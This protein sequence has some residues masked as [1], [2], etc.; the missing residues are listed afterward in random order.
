MPDPAAAMANPASTSFDL[1][2]P[3]VV[4]VAGTAVRLG[5][6]RQVAVLARLLLTPG[7]V[8]SMEQLAESV[9]DGDLPARPEV[10]IRSYIS[11]LR[12]S[13]EPARHPGDRQSC[14]E[15]IAPG[16]R[17]AVDPGAIDA[18]RFEQLVAQG[19]SALGRGDAAPAA[20]HLASALRL[21][22]GEPCE[23]LVDTDAL[24]AYRSRLAELRLVATEQWFEARLALGEHEALT[25]DLEAV[26]AEHPRRERLTELAMLAL[27]RAGRQSEAL[28]ACRRLRALLV[29]QLGI[30]PGPRV[31]ALEHKIL[32]HDPSLLLPGSA[33][34]AS[35][36]A[37]V[38][39]AA[40]PAGAGPVGGGPGTAEVSV[41][42]GTADD[43]AA[44][45]TAAADGAAPDGSGH[46][47]G[48]AP[49][50]GR[51]S[52][53]DETADAREPGERAPGDEGLLLG[54]G[55][56][57]Q[58]FE[59]VLGRTREL[60]VLAGLEVALDQ[61][62]SAT[63]VVTGE[64]GSG[65][66]ALLG[67]VADRGASAGAA[68]AWGR[69]REVARAQVLWPW[70]QIL[71]HL[72]AI[73]SAATGQ[74]DP[75]AHRGGP[76]PALSELVR[77][78]LVAGPVPGGDPDGRSPVPPRDPGE[79]TALFP[80]I[81][82]YL[83]QLAGRRPVLVVIDD[84]HWADE[85]SLELLA[86]A[87]TA[88]SADRVAFSV[89]WRHTEDGPSTVRRALR[90]LIRLPGLHR[91]E[92]AG[93]PVEAVT[94]LVAILRPD[95]PQPD[96][97]APALHEATAGNPFLIRQMLQSATEGAAPGPWPP[98]P[99]ELLAAVLGPAPPTTV[100]EQIALRAERAHPSAP[101]VLTVAALSRTPLTA[102]VVAEA[103]ELPL[104]EVE[105]AL[106]QA[107]QA[108][109]LVADSPQERTYR[110]VH[111]VAAR[112]LTAP[113]TGPRLARL[114]ATLGHARWRAGGPS[115]ELVH[116]FARARS[117][118]T[119][120]LAARFALMALQ[121]S[122]AFEL[123][124][125]AE[126]LAA[127]SLELAA[128]LGGAE[129]LGMELAL[130]EAQVARLRGESERQLRATAVAR[131][132]A[133]RSGGPDA[134]VLALLAGTGPHPAGP[135]FAAVAWDGHVDPL[136]VDIS[137]W[138]DQ[139]AGNGATDQGWWPVLAARRARLE[140]RIAPSDGGAGNRH[141]H[142]GIDRA[143]PGSDP[144]IALWRERALAALDTGSDEEL[145]ALAAGPSSGV[146]GVAQATG[147]DRLLARRLATVAGRGAPESTSSPA[148]LIDLDGGTGEGIGSPWHRPPRSVLELD[149]T[150]TA[151]SAGL[152]GGLVAPSAADLIDRLALWS[153]RTG[154]APA[155]IRWLRCLALWEK[156]SPA[157][158]EAEAGGS[159]RTGELLAWRAV[160]AAEGGSPVRAGALLDQAL[161]LD[162][163]PDLDLDLDPDLDPDL[164]LDPA[165]RAGTGRWGRAERCL[166]LLAAARAGH[167]RAIEHFGRRLTPGPPVA[168]ALA[169]MAVIGPVDWFRGVGGLAAG[170][171]K[172]AATLFERA[173]EIARRHRAPA[174]RLRALAGLAEAAAMAGDEEGRLRHHAEA[175]AVATAT[176]TGSGWFERWSAGPGAAL[177]PASATTA[178][179]GVHGLQ[180][181]SNRFATR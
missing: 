108:G 145:A 105:E 41:G 63:V 123:L 163:D 101:A 61:G 20:S 154:I 13:I 120:L 110:F 15:S 160:A 53:P 80:A 33:T 67:K 88:L 7:Q 43:P 68:V 115:A 77:A 104:D 31:Q 46:V 94:E 169:G 57:D 156:G 117:A 81:V 35:P 19:R 24:M 106:E 34:A 48:D 70:S 170:D 78:G 136:A 159:T 11:N 147:H 5:G 14:I 100:Q 155:A 55:G 28:A 73:D 42:G 167:G 151:L 178:P 133:R 95:L 86:F 64:P 111:P 119:S 60:A 171:P 114:H 166:L 83:R 16:Y 113:L 75:P 10:A 23:G 69:C 121:E 146:A 84:A 142:G 141:D 158:L 161:D 168:S 66:S 6:P 132:L 74:A 125:E 139:E 180:S 148:A 49:D 29:E 127:T 39:I 3:L 37:P 153:G 89:A 87:G 50:E 9:W 177:S 109:L 129:A 52:A 85:A 99:G 150:L 138:P 47:Q 144:G 36:S 134:E 45:T 93:M 181:T 2:G 8:V 96:V 40:H 54:D 112:A 157:E 107:V 65:K 79:A 12:R 118:G 59:L 71:Q 135:A 130:I 152:A 176:G 149:Q 92:L 137:A 32:T 90:D 76:D 143:D 174:W 103:V 102:E 122:S 22:R 62:R 172:A 30:D 165:A 38:P 4:T 91:I 72:A 1:L 97:L 116:H 26:L 162:P 131:S 128:G 17:L 140:R 98:G 58:G 56:A 175:S 27:Y 18:H 82:R 124:A 126:G 25:P 173:D 164:D 21:W 179:T 44:G 51:S